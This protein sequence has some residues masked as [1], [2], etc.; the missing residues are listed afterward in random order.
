MDMRAL[1]LRIRGDVVI[2][3]D[4]DYE[5]VRA[6]LVWNGRKPD[7]FP[8]IIVKAKDAGDVQAAVRFAAAHGKRVCVRGGGH[9]WSG[10]AV[11]D[12]IVID[13]A[14]MDALVIDPEA[15][16][17][18]AEPGMRNGRLTE[19]LAEHGLAFPA[20][21]CASV[22]L[23]GYLLGGG[24]GWNSGAWGVACH[25]V[26]SV[27]V[28]LAD[29]S[30]VTASVAEN[31]DIFWAARG[32]GPEF[33]GVVVAYR[34]RLHPLPQAIRTS[35]WTYRPDRGE[36]VEDWMNRTMRQVPRT[37]E[38]TAVM[39]SAPPPLASQAEKTLT[40]VAT[41]FADT[42]EEA[43]ETLA[44]IKAGAPEGALDVQLSLPTSFAVLYQII[45][46]FF[47]E[48]RRFAADTNWSDD[49]AM[50]MK[51]LTEAVEIAPSAE[52]FALAV[53]LPPLD[54]D[55]MP[56]GAF[57][58]VGPV[59]S[60]AYAVWQEASQDDANLAWLRNASDRLAPVSLGH[61]VGEADLDRAERI[62]GSFSPAAFER[63]RELRRRFDP[64]GRFH[65]LA[66]QPLRKTG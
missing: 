54:P 46:Q 17:A 62:R 37:V 32:A 22:P 14:A 31:T 6:G 56:P 10:L 19:A 39:A 12:G 41:I 65:R 16:T 57:S 18:R 34:L 24:F 4:A 36:A 3:D 66:A 27:E 2:R 55:L 43:Q 52:S 58:M 21:H 60:C 42:E 15:R 7:R 23:S 50:L 8:E 59:F 35:L 61:Y 28:V 63:L 20:G 33:F 11:Q 53:V 38:F 30:L 44:T 5:A 64:A 26:E 25:N 9:H 48:G 49:P 13:L 45:G 40:A 47:P 51:R 29:G 1:R